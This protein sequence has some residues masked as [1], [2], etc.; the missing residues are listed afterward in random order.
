LETFGVTRRATRILTQGEKSI[1]TNF[2]AD[3]YVYS[4]LGGQATIQ[5]CPILALGR[6]ED[7]GR[8]RKTLEP[9]PVFMRKCELVTVGGK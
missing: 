2:I 1:S 5:Y 9:C 6:R 4:R 8:L 3:E 7:A